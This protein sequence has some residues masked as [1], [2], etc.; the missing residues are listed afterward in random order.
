MLSEAGLRGHGVSPWVGPSARFDLSA[1]AVEL[2]D[3]AEYLTQPLCGEGGSQ[4]HDVVADYTFHS[5]R[6][7]M[8]R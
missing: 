1:G 3:G 8:K 6:R 5:V 2:S 4:L 7:A